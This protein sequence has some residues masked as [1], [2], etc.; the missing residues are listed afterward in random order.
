MCNHDKMKAQGG[1]LLIQT[2]I[3]TKMKDKDTKTHRETETEIRHLQAQEEFL[4]TSAPRI[5]ED[6]RLQAT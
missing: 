1:G 2:F 3:F 5:K 6:S 4:Q